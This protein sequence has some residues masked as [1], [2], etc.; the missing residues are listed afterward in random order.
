MDG[1][2]GACMLICGAGSF[3]SLDKCAESLD[4]ELRT[5][6]LPTALLIRSTITLSA[7]AESSLEKANDDCL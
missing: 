7:G 2:P 3:I 4:K 5:V 1:N 6:P